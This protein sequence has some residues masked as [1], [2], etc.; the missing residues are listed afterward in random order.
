MS[1]RRT[2]SDRPRGWSQESGSSQDEDVILYQGNR[3]S[4]GPDRHPSVPP[5]EITAQKDD[6]FAKFLKKHSSPNHQ[7]V[8]AG[9]RIVPMEQQPRPPIFTLPAA[10]QDSEEQKPNMRSGVNGVTKTALA[11]HE[12][13]K[14]GATANNAKPQPA[15]TGFT[16]SSVPGPGAN[17]PASINPFGF[18]FS[19]IHANY[20]QAGSTAPY[21]TGMPADPY[22]AMMS[23]QMYPAGAI[24]FLGFTGPVGA[25]FAM[26]L[27]ANAQMLGFPPSGGIPTSPTDQPLTS[28]HARRMHAD[29]V[30]RFEE[31]EE[32]L[33][34]MDRHRAMREHDPY[35][36]QQRLAI[37]T[38]RSEVKSAIS[39]WEKY[40][41][42]N[43]QDMSMNS[44]TGAHS[45]LN[46][47]A[48]SYV[49]IRVR[50]STETLSDNNPSGL[51]PNGADSS[52]GKPDFV[53]DSTR[54]PIP[55]VPP[56]GKSASLHINVKQEAAPK[57]HQIEVDDWGIRVGPAPPELQRQQEEVAKALS[58][59]ASISP[60]TS[61]DNTAMYTPQGSSEVTPPAPP[62]DVKDLKEF[63]IQTEYESQTE[64]LPIKPGRAPP[65]VE[66][67]YELQLDAMR[68]PTGMIAKIRLPDGIITDVRGCSL[69]RPPSFEMDEFE[70][71]YWTTKPT[72]TQEMLDSFLEVRR[73][74]D[75]DA[76][77]EIQALGLERF[78]LP[79]P[80]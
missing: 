63:K 22:S 75:K 7:R 57:N 49:P 32:Q 60:L 3:A 67:S 68:L 18:D 14:A 15:T 78:V 19:A 31:L 53:V 48:S 6:G 8:T 76:S 64:W 11:G 30:A 46:V 61:G 24:P 20:L 70:Q 2:S 37:V 54:R 73:C 77:L 10:K 5:T 44:S 40:L 4:K 80:A 1:S 9:G 56:P 17:V 39:H 38:M 66:A 69:K 74:D 21:Y 28:A 50:Q 34:A 65:T 47:Q 27:F 59:Q 71:R 13:A 55:I 35:L 36:A 62:S 45:T 58:R 25:P 23:P 52:T 43:S 26:P 29:A 79:T 42:P 12:P 51:K 72:L 33:R 16:E 41:E